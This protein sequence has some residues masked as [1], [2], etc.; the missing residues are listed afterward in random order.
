M[1]ETNFGHY[2]YDLR[3][4]A[5]NNISPAVLDGEMRPCHFSEC[6]RCALKN[7]A[8]GNKCYTK[9]LLWLMEE[10]KPLPLLDN[11]EKRYLKAVI[12]PFKSRVISITKY[13]DE[14]TKD[15]FIRISIRDDTAI[16]LP[17]FKAGDMYKRMTAR[18]EYSLKELGLEAVPKE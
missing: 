5:N 7:I 13:V 2:Q 3:Y 15:A 14:E 4:L 9:L 16:L 6:E 17:V 11:R 1:K 12:R 18:K 10:Y 8:P